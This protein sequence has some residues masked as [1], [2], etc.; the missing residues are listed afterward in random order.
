MS[1]AWLAP[2]QAV[3]RKRFERTR[4]SISG[5]VEP[6]NSSAELVWLGGLTGLA[7]YVQSKT[8]LLFVCGLVIVQPVYHR[9]PGGRGIYREPFAPCAGDC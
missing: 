9:L 6:G 4:R 2:A 7:S 3:P 1:R 8:G 5:G